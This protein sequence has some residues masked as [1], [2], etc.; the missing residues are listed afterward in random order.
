M[1]S[2]P[3]LVVFTNDVDIQQQA[4]DMS[5]CAT[6]EERFELPKDLEIAV[7]MGTAPFS[8]VETDGAAVDVH[9]SKEDRDAFPS[10]LLVDLAS[11]LQ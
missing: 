4:L 9:F 6:A 2:S 1:P 7:A 8:G 10:D 11:G 5:K 3:T